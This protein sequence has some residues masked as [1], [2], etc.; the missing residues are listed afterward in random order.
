MTSPDDLRIGDAERDAVMSALREHFAQGRLTH[1]ELDER[2][3]AVLAARTAGALR[4][5]TADLPGPSGAH[6]P[7]GRPA[8][9]GGP[10]WPVGPAWH[11]PRPVEGGHRWPG[12]WAPPSPGDVAAWRHHVAEARRGHLRHRHHGG[13]PVLL[14]VLAI[15]VIASVVSGSLAPVFGVVKVLFLAWLVL[16]VFGLARHRRHHHRARLGRRL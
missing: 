14:F 7:S 3:D 2:L 12:A 4:Q 9:S 15:I 11:G 1:D 16:A 5:V 10:G 6:D 13:P 8:R